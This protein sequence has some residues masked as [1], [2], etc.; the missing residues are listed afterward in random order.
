MQVAKGLPDRR[1]SSL[2]FVL[3]V[4][5]GICLLCPPVQAKADNSGDSETNI[6]ELTVTATK[7]TTKLDKVPTNITVVSRQTLDRYPEHYNVMTLL[8]QLNIPGLYFPVNTF[9]SG[10]ASAR[11]STRGSEVSAWG[12]K[13]MI[14]GIELTRGNGTVAGS[15]LAVHDIERIEIIKT[16]SAE[17]G[18]QALGGVINIITRTARDKVEGKAGVAFSS[19]GGGN[20]YSVINGAQDKWDYYI[21]VSAQREDG[22]QDNG[23]QDGN[24]LYTKVGYGLSDD[25]QLTFHGSYND[26]KG[27][28]AVGLTRELFDQDPSQ[29]PNTGADYDYDAED[30]LGALVFEQQW[31]AYELMAKMELQATKF[32]MFLEAFADKN[33]MYLDQSLWQAHPE[34]NLTLN[35]DIAGMVNKMVI[36]G[37]FRHHELNAKKYSATSFNDIGAINQDFLRVDKS[38]AG[39]FQ[40]ELRITDAFTMTAG[41]RYDYFDL[42]QT[43]NIASSDSWTQ[44]TGD[45]SP[46]LGVTYQFCD[47]VNLFAGFNSGLKSPVRL[48]MYYTNG[49]LDPEKLRAY[50]AGIRGDIAG[51][52]NYNMAL[53]WQKVTDK[54]VRASTDAEYENAGETSSKGV[55]L[56][57]GAQLP[58]NFYATASFTYQ[59]SEFEEFT[60][61]GVDYAGKRLTGV[62]DVIFALTL[63]HRDE[64]FGDIS[65]S[66]VYTGKRYFNYANTNEDDAF[67][68]LNARY[69][70]RI[71][72]VEVYLVGNNLFDESAVGSGSGNPGSEK[73]YAIS[74]FNAILGMNVTF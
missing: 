40:D 10:S 2:G 35:H 73:L 63:G 67:W 30:M 19:L 11:T 74:G 20:G 62:P 58:E 53:F 26:A 46:K 38:Y 48:S 71:G 57:A 13:V 4:L 47:E 33:G 23:Y 72:R 28:Y 1:R 31:G 61:M 59:Q 14:N 54:F 6:G 66:P 32:Q 41:L 69:S 51:W 56:G 65:L 21:D 22:Y 8:R 5:I 52:L 44:G 9:G 60:S 7:M 18:D 50:E 64:R 70:K 43:A 3:T 34:V 27:T 16:P 17:Y 36:G 25:A 55:E 12:M 39:F 24:N 15:R 29:N 37:E 49:Q 42:D 45:I 68:V